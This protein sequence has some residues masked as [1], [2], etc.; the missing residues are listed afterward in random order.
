MATTVATVDVSALSPALRGDVQQ[1]VT[2]L[3]GTDATAVASA[4]ARLEADFRLALNLVFDVMS[5]GAD[6]TGTLDS[7]PAFRTALAA[8]TA[9]ATAANPTILSSSQP[10]T[11]AVCPQPDD[12]PAFGGLVPIFLWVAGNEN[13]IWQGCDPT[14]GRMRL[15]GYMPGLRDP[16]TTW[17]D[18]GDSYS[19]IQRFTMFMYFSDSVD[20]PGRFRINSID[21]S[22]GC[23]YDG[24][25]TVGGSLGVGSLTVA[26]GG[27]GYQVGDVLGLDFPFAV[28]GVN[29]PR[30]ASF[31]VTA[32]D[33]A[34]AVT[35]L[36][37]AAMGAYAAINHV[38]LNV[39]GGSGTGGVVSILWK[40]TGNGWDMSHKFLLVNGQCSVAGVIL[41]DCNVEGF[42][43]EILYSGGSAL[44][45]LEFHNGSM[46]NCSGSTVSASAAVT[47]TNTVF[48]ANTYNSVEC[49]AVN[50]QQS[51]TADGCVFKNVVWA[52][53]GGPTDDVTKSFCKITN[54]TVNGTILLA[55]RV[56]NVSLDRIAF[57]ATPYGST[58]AL[59]TGGVANVN[60]SVTNCTFRGFPNNMLFQGSGWTNLRVANCTVDRGGLFQGTIGPSTGIVVDGT[61]FGSDA[62]GLC[63]Q[64]GYGGP[65]TALFANS[66]YTGVPIVG[67][68]ID[69]WPPPGTET[70][71]P[72]APCTDYT[73]LNAGSRPAI[74]VL[75]TTSRNYPV[76]FTTTVF[77]YAGEGLWI[78]PADP[79]V[80][81]WTSDVNVPVGQLV[82]GGGVV[83]PGTT[84]PTGV[85]I[86][87]NASSLWEL[88]P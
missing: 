85:K 86:R 20:V 72:V 54:S 62:N 78:M 17:I 52:A 49:Q 65:G 6:P 67:T 51:F 22:G 10:G 73:V 40:P 15:K 58:V 44:E 8:A 43:G 47:L 81:T 5:Y 27:S 33:S 34:G 77:S 7:T 16:N 13:V 83:T 68:K 21:F 1:T 14:R 88:V 38:P 19:R 64:G 24:D 70:N 71:Q 56:Y 48:G 35:G 76:G 28:N 61:T 50:N 53:L 79:K 36:S 59:N 87:F 9:A 75:D 57:D 84:A 45:V 39:T 31:T 63:G 41:N 69:D 25:F 18:T 46:D 42:R 11:Y 60:G 74:G 2:A 3:A 29:G 66:I 26:A 12:P 37:V 23:A 32:V 82:R 55:S 4:V 30:P 80:N